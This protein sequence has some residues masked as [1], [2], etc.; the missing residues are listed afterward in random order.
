M[1]NLKGQSTCCKAKGEWA[2]KD[3]G[4]ISNSPF[5]ICSKCKQGHSIINVKDIV[6]L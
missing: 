6:I 2:T 5:I 1:K 4:V 3:K